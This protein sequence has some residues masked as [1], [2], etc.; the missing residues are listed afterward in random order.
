MMVGLILMKLG[1]SSQK[2]RPPNTTTS[3]AVMSGTG[4]KRPSRIH[5][6]TSARTVATI[7]T[8]VAQ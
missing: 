6:A 5:E 8:P 4:E 1:S 3:T 2:V 7:R